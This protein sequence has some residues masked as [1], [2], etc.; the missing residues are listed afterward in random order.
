M[1]IILGGIRGTIPVSGNEF[2]EYGGD[3][4]S[5]MVEGENDS[6]V[7]ID[8]GTGLRY[9]DRY[10]SSTKTSPQI[11]IFMTHYHLD[12]L[13]GMPLFT[14][15]YKIAWKLRITGPRLEGHTVEDA[16][17]RMLDRPFWPLQLNA[18]KAKVDFSVID[19]LKPAIN[20]IRNL[21]ITWCPVHH[22]GGCV[23]YRV[24]EANT[25]LSMIFAT[26]IEWTESTDEEKSRFI[27][28]C[29]KP[30]PAHILLFDGHFSPK[31]MTT[32]RG[33]GHSSWENAVDVARASGIKRL[34][35]IHHAPDHTDSA[36]A[37]LENDIRREFP[38]A[39]LARA[40]Q[41]I[42]I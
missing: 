34:L 42:D 7:I 20:R 40:Q 13:I 18:M 6:R 10:L 37:E 4:T 8:M 9:I 33:W 2:N 32:Y 31:T 21:A 16:M 1:K 19:P 24:T 28:F 25:G 38:G 12:H 15:L 27:D 3:T 5:I 17:N 26:D 39:T 29:S 35:I 23:A 22:P 11:E 14:P 36:L 41:I 30:T